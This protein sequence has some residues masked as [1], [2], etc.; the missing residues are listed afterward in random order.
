MDQESGCGIFQS[1]A[2]L[3]WC[4]FF[5]P[6]SGPSLEPFGHYPPPTPPPPPLALCA[7][8][9]ATTDKLSTHVTFP[10]HGLRLHHLASPECAA[11]V[12]PDD[13]TYELYAV[14]NHYGGSLSGAAATVDEMGKRAG[15]NG[16]ES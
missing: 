6:L 4:R 5:R 7:E 8:Q 1:R 14:S 16:V 11:A 12:G 2:F 10:L 15:W 3:F 9:C 13:C